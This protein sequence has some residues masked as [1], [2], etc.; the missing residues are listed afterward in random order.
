MSV[1]RVSA[2]APLSRMLRGAAALLLLGAA[3]PGYA[4]DAPW[5]QEVD[6][7]GFLSSSFT[8]NFNEPD[9]ARNDFRIFDGDHNSFTLDV[10]QLS[11]QRGVAGPGET[12]FRFDLVAGSV[13]PPVAAV[14]PGRQVDVHQGYLS[15]IAPLGKGLRLDVGK[16]YT[17]MG[18]ELVEGVDG[19]NEQHSRSFLFGYAIPLLHAGAKAS[20][21]V[22]EKLSVMAGVVNGWDNPVEN[23]SS[24]SIVAQVAATPAEGASMA[25]NFIYG[26]ELAADDGTGRWVVDLTG[27][28]AV[29]PKVRLGVNF[30]LGREEYLKTFPPADTLRKATR[31]GS[32]AE[33]EDT[34]WMGLA[35]YLRWEVSPKVVLNLRGELFDDQ[36]G[37]RTG[38]GEAI[39]LTEFTITPEY[40]L[41]EAMSIRGE[42]RVDMADE[43]VF[44]QSTEDGEELVKSQPTV[45]IN[46]VYTF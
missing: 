44:T 23:N 40:R 18:Y 9:A 34:R 39:Q 20:L 27:G 43:K 29:T 21:P 24:K 25:A 7:R 16:F 28:Y 12:G 37:Y 17:H 8:W 14:D 45:G 15:W 42:L 46:C 19:W 4:E 38:V 32:D 26:P 31:D 33:E 13:I 5:Y 2:L 6:V 22:G 41:S 36:D 10:A 35:G 1:P 11:L 30:D 3:L